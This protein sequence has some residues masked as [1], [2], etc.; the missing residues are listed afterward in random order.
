MVQL[1]NITA[2][3][4]SSVRVC[5]SIDSS[6][7]LQ[8]RFRPLHHFVLCYSCSHGLTPN[9]PDIPIYTP[10]PDGGILR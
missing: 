1:W 7:L 10:L 6:P 4:R 5:L 3:D 2:K 8:E 9:R